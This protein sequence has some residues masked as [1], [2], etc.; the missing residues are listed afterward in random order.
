MTRGLYLHVGILDI[1][2]A[3]RIGL[4]E[5]IFKKYFLYNSFI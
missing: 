2:T 5:F 3:Q 4:H 1:H